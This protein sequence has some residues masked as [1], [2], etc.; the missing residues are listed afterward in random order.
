MTSQ[1]IQENKVDEAI[2]AISTN[3]THRSYTSKKCV[4]I[5]CLVTGACISVLAKY[6]SYPVSKEAGVSIFGDNSTGYRFGIVFQAFYSK[7]FFVLEM[8][9]LGGILSFLV[10]PATPQESRLGN[11]R[12]ACSKV[13]LGAVLVVA[14][15]F[16]RYPFSIPAMEYNPSNKW[17]AGGFSLVASLFIPMGSLM[18]SFKKAIDFSKCSGSNEL[19]KAKLSFIK[20]IEALQSELLDSSIDNQAQVEDAIDQIDE[21]TTTGNEYLNTYISFFFEK[22]IKNNLSKKVLS[23]I[24][25]LFLTGVLEYAIASYT[26]RLTKKLVTED[27]FFAVAFSIFAVLTTFHIYTKAIYAA[28]YRCIDSLSNRCCYSPKLTIAE[29]VYPVSI[30]IL[31]SIEFISNIIALGAWYQI[32]NSFFEDNSKYFFVPVLLLTLFETL[33]T[34]SNDKINDIFLSTTIINCF[35]SENQKKAINT[36]KKLNRIKSVIDLSSEWEFMVFYRRLNDK[37]KPGLFSSEQI[38]KLNEIKT[39]T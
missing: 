10:G 37:I 33:Q 4:K 31:K 11:K 2:Y 1:L 35:C 32:W 3:Y 28:N 30:G 38:R 39:S 27:N 16:A 13:I 26:Y 12:S 8:W 15:V 20:A 36:H 9:A 5:I 23:S 34:S 22:E 7:A 21:T 25:T 17:F 18:L 29:R 6:Y 24:A 14:A 19:K